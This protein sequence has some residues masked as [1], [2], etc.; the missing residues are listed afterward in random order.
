MD[1]EHD[2]GRFGPESI[3]PVD[4]KLSRYLLD[5]HGRGLAILIA[6]YGIAIACL[7]FS[8]WFIMGEAGG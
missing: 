5:G 2:C 1:H 3:P 6:I 7:F 4:R 8:F